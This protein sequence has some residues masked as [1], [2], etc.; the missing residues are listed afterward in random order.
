MKLF[1]IL[2][3]FLLILPS[4]NYASNNLYN[5][6][7]YSNNSYSLR[8]GYFPHSGEILTSE[9]FSISSASN[10]EFNHFID[11]GF[12]ID[13]YKELGK[14]SEKGGLIFAGFNCAHLI[15]FNKQPVIIRFITGFTIQPYPAL[16]NILEL[17]LP[18]I[19]LIIIPP[20]IF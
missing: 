1:A 5:D 6:S 11:F 2:I 20:L 3:F 17:D 12:Y 14:S 4:L 15:N 13:I 7:V 16:T 10:G 18:L 9:G 19:D 8:I